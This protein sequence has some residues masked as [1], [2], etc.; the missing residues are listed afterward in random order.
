M[1]HLILKVCSVC[2]VQTWEQTLRTTA[3]IS[4]QL[5]I[6]YHRTKLQSSICDACY[7][8][9]RWLSR[10]HVREVHA[11]WRKGDNSWIGQNSPQVGHRDQK[12]NDVEN[13]HID[14]AP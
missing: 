6:I 7:R 1:V 5:H 2:T 8:F 10:M 4:L 11:R 13:D 9:F 12:D 3:L 14:A